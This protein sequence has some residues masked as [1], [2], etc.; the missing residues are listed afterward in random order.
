M[1]HSILKFFIQVSIYLFFS[2]NIFSQSFIISG[3]IVDGGTNEPLKNVSVQLKG[4][5]N[6]GILSKD[7]GSFILTAIHWSDSL[8]FTCIGY[9]TRYFRLPK[10]YLTGLQVKMQPAAQSLA[11][12]IIFGNK[13]DKEPGRRYMQ[14]VIDNKKFNNPGRFNSYSSREYLRHEVDISNLDEAAVY[15]KGLKA[16]TINIY[17]SAGPGNATVL[18]LYFSENVFDTYHS[19]SPSIDRK[20]LVAKK[21]LGLETD[22]FLWQLDK[23]NFS[24]NIYNNWLPIFN[25]T[26][27]SPLNDNAFN[28]Y[29]YFF[30]DSN[31]VNNKKVYTI[32]FIPKEKYETAFSGTLVIND[33]TYSIQ[34]IEMHL[35]LTANLDFIK[36]VR[37]KEEYNLI[38]DSATHKMEY[39]PYK[40]SSTVEFETGLELLGIPV[41]P[42]KKKVR[43]ASVNTTVIG[44][45]NINSPMS[46]EFAKKMKKE[47]S[48]DIQ[49]PDSY[50]KENRFGD[51]L[52]QHEKNIYVMS[53]S[54]KKNRRYSFDAKV[55]NMGATGFWNFKDRIRLGPYFDLLSTNNIEGLRFRTGFW[56]MEKFNKKLNFNGYIAYGTKDEQFKGGG[57]IKYLWNRAKWTRTSLFA[58]SDYDFMTEGDDN[59]DEDNLINSYFRKNIPTTRIY[60]KQIVLGHEQYISRNFSIN[61]GLLYKEMKPVFD[62][63]Y[64]P[65]NKETEMPI[66][67]IF[68]RTLPQ[69]EASVEFRFTRNERNFTFNYDL[70]HY[71]T[72]HPIFTVD[73]TSSL[74]IGNAQFNYQKVK[75]E[76]EQQLRLPP[77]SLFYY[78]VRVSKT[79]GTAPYLLLNIP[80]GNEY[81]VA[82]RELFNTMIPYEFAADEFV[83]L[84]SR[85]YL[86]GVFFNKIP[87][88]KKLGWRERFSFSGYA[89]RM[90]VANRNYNKGEF[91]TV[92]DKHPFMEAGV[93]IENIFHVFSI[94]YYYRLSNVTAPGMHKGAFFPGVNIT[95]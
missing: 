51:S 60:L 42:G 65:L 46:E 61:G 71:D 93:G 57:G 6:N 79:F 3:K 53:D 66:D 86:G 5:P 34:K 80:A 2:Q 92:P 55:I 70:Y 40:Y 44:D 52:T 20:N 64:H 50:W 26:F 31:I 73:F 49:K 87:F 75:F 38:I 15:G 62:F 84:F 4:F 89:G 63:Y 95:F 28:Y 8:E 32:R 13:G 48:A 77:K 9:Q 12:V 30:Q 45:I 72:Y 39:I 88:I 16:L 36:D 17:R 27:A 91:F 76:I 90:S 69:A 83:S 74:K 41:T 68:L 67:S 23:F 25:Q 33:S 54:L 85:F 11:A 22:K 19:N 7:D 78:K 35:S 18:P 43:L 94:D 1:F 59:L 10:D 37:Y 14:K 24:F 82:S 47:S 56:T 21:T 58:S 29:N 81:Y